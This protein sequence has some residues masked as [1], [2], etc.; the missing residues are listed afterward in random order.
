[1][2]KNIL[3]FERLMYA[4]L[5]VALVDFAPAS[6]SLIASDFREILLGLAIIGAISI[7]LPAL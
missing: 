3:R 5:A 6:T 1:M 7:V 4:S 2:P